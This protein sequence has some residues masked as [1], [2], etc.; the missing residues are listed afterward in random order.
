MNILIIE[1][2]EFLARQISRIF[3]SKIISN[4]IRVIASLSA[5]LSEMHLI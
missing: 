3:E 5:F 4:R 1:D 2:D